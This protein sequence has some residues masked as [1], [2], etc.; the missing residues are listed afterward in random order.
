MTRKFIGIMLTVLL[1]F[2]IALPVQAATRSVGMDALE[3]EKELV[4]KAP[5]S[6]LSMVF[7]VPRLAK[8]YSASAT[9]S[10]TPSPQLHEDAL[11]SFYLNDKLLE[12][13]T[14]KQLRAQKK[15]TVNLPLDGEFRDAF[16]LQIKANMFIS[17]DLC[18]DYYTGGLFYTVHNDTKVDL[19][20]DMMPV[21]SVADFFGNFQQS[22]LIVVPNNAG[23][24]EMTPAAWAFGIV[25]KNYPHLD[26]QIVKAGEV[27]DRPNTPRIWVALRNQLPAYFNKTQAGIELADPNTL[28][29]SAGS[30]SELESLSR[31]LA[32][33]PVFP[34]NSLVGRNLE[35][36]SAE[37]PDGKGTERISFGNQTVQEGVLQVSSDFPLYPSLWGNVPEKMGIH[38]EGSNMVAFDQA[39]PA[40]LDVFFNSKLLHSSTLDH[41]GQFSREIVLPA[42]TELLSKNNLNV[43]VN[44]PEEQGQ[45]LIRGTTHTVQVSPGS[46]MWGTGQQKLDHFEWS[47]IGIFFARQGTVLLDEKLG[48]P[49]KMIAELMVFLN[50]QLPTATYAFPT[51][52]TLASQTFLPP[53]Q[54]VVALINAGNE[55][56]FLQDLM[57]ILQGQGAAGYQ[58]NNPPIPTELQPNLNSVVGKIAGNNGA[59]VVVFSTK[60]NGG[61]LVAAL[62]FLNRPGQYTPLVGNV[63]AFR[64]PG[65]IFSADVRDADNSTAVIQPVSQGVFTRYWGQYKKPII[66]VG[67]TFA[68]LILL[69]LFFFGF[70]RK[71]KT[72]QARAEEVR[73]E[74]FE[75]PLHR[76]ET[77]VPILETVT[78]ATALPTEQQNRNRLRKNVAIHIK[79][80]IASRELSAAVPE[81]TGA[82]PLWETWIARDSAQ[83][84]SANIPEEIVAAGEKVTFEEPEPLWETWIVR[85]SA[86]GQ[87]ASIPEELVAAEEKVTFEESEPLWETWI[88][89][90]STQGQSASIPEKLVAAEENVTFEKPASA[91]EPWIVSDAA[92]ATS[93]SKPEAIPDEEIA[94]PPQ[95][96]PAWE[97]R[98]VRD[99]NAE[100]KVSPAK[101][102][103]TWEAWIMRDTAKDASESISELSSEEAN[104]A[105]AKMAS[106]DSVAAEV[107]TPNP[108]KPANAGKIIR[109]NLFI[110]GT[111]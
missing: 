95:T 66:F 33:L 26:V 93:A 18:R 13:K 109:R 75:E 94:T 36:N 41:A 37:N 100:L 90:D 63:M 10:L 6:S 76:E 61:L 103:P 79:S 9:F 46:Y 72:E 111:R 101:T 67:A 35:G 60:Q 5:N 30:V 62:R 49:L 1:V 51:L 78:A 73:E 102:V 4:V 104:V 15:I 96:V 27:G 70:N 44:Y 43:Q 42:G 65:R 56:P 105:P 83:D 16:R 34:R 91:W 82:A 54:Y 3:F 24:A 59:P 57:P 12:S 17:N 38:L 48:D 20:Y 80:K 58:D 45:C 14:V 108:K 84:H 39:R 85:D 106:P 55:P 86:Q 89:R 68:G 29:L 40:R 81:L 107:D 50:R 11:F 23:L 22:A 31:Q 21:R 19:N 7:P 71:P 64:Q 88:A 28:L 53:D 52:Q 77:T 32:D 87:S 25:K 8:I 97:P 110:S 47:N 99:S 92:Q 69:L 74:I 98:I 2:H